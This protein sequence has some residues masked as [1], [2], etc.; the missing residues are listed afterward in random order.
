[1]KLTKAFFEGI[2]E[3]IV[4]ARATV[5]RGVDL[6]QVY[7]NFEIGRRVF[8]QEQQGKGRAAYGKEVIKA[9]SERLTAEFGQ[10]F[11]TSN[12]AYIRSFFLIRVIVVRFNEQLFLIC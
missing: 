5:A 8:E 1:M 4:S 2:R 7:T 9:L 11:S 12:L 6:V 10:G 3:L